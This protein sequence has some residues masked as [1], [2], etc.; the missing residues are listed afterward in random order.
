MK[1]LHDIFNS[2]GSHSAEHPVDLM[3]VRQS[4][5]RPCLFVFGFPRKC[6]TVES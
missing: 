4:K 5:I 1:I 6:V 2:L 3:E